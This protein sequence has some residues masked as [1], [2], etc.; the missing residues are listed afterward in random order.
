MCTQVQPVIAPVSGLRWHKLWL[1]DAMGRRSLWM[2]TWRWALPTLA[3]GAVLSLGLLPVCAK[4]E[5]FDSLMV[6]VRNDGAAL[7]QVSDRLYGQKLAL[8]QRAVVDEWLRA[9]VHD[10]RLEREVHKFYTRA[11]I[12]PNHD[13]AK[14]P[15][16]VAATMSR[17]MVPGMKRLGVEPQVQ[18]WKL[19]LD[20]LEGVPVSLCAKTVKPPWGGSLW[21]QAVRIRA[22]TLHRDDFKAF[23]SAD[24]MALEA[25][26]SDAP[27][28]PK[29]S[30]QQ[31]GAMTTAYEVVLDRRMRRFSSGTIERV[32]GN[33][34]AAAPGEL[35][36]VAQEVMAAALD[37]KEPHLSWYFAS[38]L[39]P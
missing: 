6:Q 27:P 4:A 10:V 18:R 11:R 14:F 2:S 7:K 23:V 19:L 1:E 30:V 34:G 28:L 22:T 39:A 17:L 32:F 36:D 31:Y 8:D 16:I 29:L 21:Q 13:D 3:M 15:L 26:L 25:E 20:V 5:V 35:C 24:R 12:L 37:L 9:A 33:P 38:N